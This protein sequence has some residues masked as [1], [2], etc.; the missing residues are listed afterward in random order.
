MALT[1]ELV[2]ACRRE[3]A[4]SGPEVGLPHLDDD[5]YL[6]IAQSLIA[7]RSIPGPL[8]VFGYGSLIWKPEIP[9]EEERIAVAHGWHRAFCIR[10]RRWRGTPEEPGL[11]LGLLRGGSCT[12]LALRLPD[13]DAAFQI[14]TLLRREMTA[15]PPT[16]RPV[17]MKVQTS[18]GAVEA[19]GFVANPAGRTYA[20][21]IP[22]EEAAR[23]LAS[24]CGHVGSGAD[25][26]YNTVFSLERLGIHDSGLWRLQEQ[27][28][29]AIQRRLAAERAPAV[30]LIGL[31]RE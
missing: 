21:P 17:W 16:Y 14:Q 7:S 15:K 13:G 23:V 5:D 3:I 26:L 9:H 28:A 22:A 20:G 1:P 2:A 30:D 31:R 19:L 29:L 27:V 10:L 4:D 25:Y 8:W 6:A 18:G 12:G 11:M 24:A